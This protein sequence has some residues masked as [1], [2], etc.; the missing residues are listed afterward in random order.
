LTVFINFILFFH[1]FQVRRVSTTGQSK[2]LRVLRSSTFPALAAVAAIEAMNGQYLGNRPITIFHTLTPSKIPKVNDM[3]LQQ[4]NCWLHR[5]QLLRQTRHSH[6]LFADAPPM[7]PP[8]SVM[9]MHDGCASWITSSSS[10]T[11]AIIRP[12]GGDGWNHHLSTTVAF[13]L[14]TQGGGGANLSPS[15]SFFHLNF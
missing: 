8:M 3:G 6:Q 2:T 5:I 12:S 10:S 7:P 1:D 4:I 9:P 14:T 13:L 15:F 11:A